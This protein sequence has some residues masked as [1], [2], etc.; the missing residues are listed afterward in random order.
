MGEHG[1]G[2][3]TGVRPIG[4]RLNALVAATIAR[5]KT[6]RVVS[7]WE[8]ARLDENDTARTG[9]HKVSQY[10][11]TDLFTVRSDDP[12]ELVSDL[13]AWERIRHVPVEDEKG[14]LVGMVSYRGVLR[15][16]T[17]L[18]RHPSHRATGS[19]AVSEIMKRDLI[20]VTPETPTLEAIA[21]MRDHRIGCLPVV[22]GGHI[23]A[24]VTEEDFVGIAGKVLE[25]SDGA[26]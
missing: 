2:P 18:M 7:D 19:N 1:P 14:R 20:T 16:L 8:R 23:V 12:I 11:T 25:E 6:D 3:T 26:L 5:Q 24:V 17:D 15:Y 4:A 21:L 13:M 10:M 9:F 22:E